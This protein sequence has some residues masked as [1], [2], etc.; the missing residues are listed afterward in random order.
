[1]KIKTIATNSI[2]AALYIVITFL[3]QPIAFSNIQFRI[4]EIFNHL[5]IFNKKY[6]FGIVIG[7]F[8][9]NLLFSTLLPYDLFF[10]VFHTILSLSITIFIGKYIKKQWLL[11]IVNSLVFSFNMFIIAY[12]LNLVLEYPFYET[13]LFTFL[14]EIVVMLIGIPLINIINKRINLQKLFD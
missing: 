12:E 14:G 6:F 1:M 9:A 8:L 2:V 10:G 13:W 3:I 7:V 5:I 4:P 11:M